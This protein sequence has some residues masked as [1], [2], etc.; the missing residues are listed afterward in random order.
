[1]QA[2]GVTTVICR[3]RDVLRLV[4]EHC[5]GRTSEPQSTSNCGKS[6]VDARIHNIVAR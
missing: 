3:S 5:C 2:R 6:I 1:M 4:H